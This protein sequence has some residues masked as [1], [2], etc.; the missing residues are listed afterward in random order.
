MSTKE[1]YYRNDL[2]TVIILATNE[3]DNLS[4]DLD[5]I[6]LSANA[7]EKAMNPFI[8][9]LAMDKLYCLFKFYGISKFVG[10]LMPNPFLYK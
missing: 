5:S 4:P 1:I 6:S 3:T 2:N 8:L 9:P 10:Y 7:F